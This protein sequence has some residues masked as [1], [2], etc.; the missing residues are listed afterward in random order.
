MNMYGHRH[1]DLEWNYTTM[2]LLVHSNLVESTAG[3]Q[4]QYLHLY[5]ITA[6]IHTAA[7][8][9]NRWA[10]KSVKHGWMRM[11]YLYSSLYVW[12]FL[13]NLVF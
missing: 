6:V 10:A 13:I 4:V 12:A 11:M 7:P 3:V 2:Y 1:V 8:S 9:S 5:G